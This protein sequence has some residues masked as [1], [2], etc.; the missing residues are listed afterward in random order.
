MTRGPRL[1]GA[2][3]VVTGGSSGI[4]LATA[5]ELHG[6]G[7]RVSLVARDGERLAAAAARVG[8]GCG[9]AS[10]D[11]TDRDALGRAVG[12]LTA[13]QGP[14]DLLVCSAGAAHAGYVEELDEAVFRAQM[15]LNYFGTLH[16]VRAVLPAMLERGRG[17][18]VAISSAA[19]LVGV[20]GYVAYAPAKH[21]V[22]GLCEALHAEVGRRGIY[23][24]CAYPPDTLTPGF[25]VE[26]RIKPAETA[27][28]SA[29]VAPKPPEVVAAAIAR[30][31]GRGQRVITA[32][33]QT[34]L[35]ARAGG[36]VGPLAE[37]VMARRLQA[38]AGTGSTGPTDS[39]GEQ[40]GEEDA[41]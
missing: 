20:F 21:A 16:A 13:G 28:V 40:G 9:W 31:I 35:L 33:L 25:E 18:I 4:G 10:A 26:N 7:A 19:A 27:A 32:D 22:R 11:V 3:A 12:E 8:A 14:V 29:M 24:A 34:A 5:R 39:G 30:G 37:R 2:H 15:E 6:R 36:L 17:G 38:V 41:E 23:V 1:A